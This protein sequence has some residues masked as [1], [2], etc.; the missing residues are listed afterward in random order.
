[1]SYWAIWLVI[2]IL[3]A[4]MEAATIN[5]VSIWFIASGIVSLFVSL[6]C[7]SFFIQFGVFV[8]LGIFLLI[9]TRPM[10]SKMVNG[11]KA[12]TNLDRIIGMEGIVTSKIKKNV[13]GEVKVDGKLWSA[14]STNTIE[15]GS[16]VKVVSMESVKLVVE[17]VVSIE[18]KAE[19]ESMEK[20][21]TAKTTASK[22]SSPK[23]SASSKKSATSKKT[24][25]RKTTTS[26]KTNGSKKKESEK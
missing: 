25:T 11:K 17:K 15:E 13:I 19:T 4:I 26:K 3:L 6:F 2:V 23:K 14:I 22:K 1:M 24:T 8:I 16:I 20:K 18:E 7:D 10:L 5:L 12:T 21:A 9:L